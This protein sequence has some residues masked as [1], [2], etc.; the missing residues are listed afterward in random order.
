MNVVIN[1]PSSICQQL[2]H[3][4]LVVLRTF[5]VP[6]TVPLSPRYNNLRRLCTLAW[7]RSFVQIMYLFKGAIMYL[8][9][10]G[11]FMYSFCTLSKNMYL[12]EIS[13]RFVQIM[14]LFK[15]AINTPFMYLCCCG[16]FMY[17]FCTFSK[18]VYLFE[19]S[20]EYAIFSKSK[21]V[22]SCT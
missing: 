1:F 15:G 7:T 5:L 8:C 20:S 4:P 2:M 3:A 6:F 16:P 10:C 21:Q 17:S 22:Q 13:S 19:I 18:N 11:P 9:R 12:F 14:Y